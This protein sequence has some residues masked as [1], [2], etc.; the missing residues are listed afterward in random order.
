LA[1]FFAGFADASSGCG[2]GCGKLSD[3]AVL[4]TVGIPLGNGL[5]MGSCL[6]LWPLEN[7]GNGTNRRDGR[8]CI[9][10]REHR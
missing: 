9:A 10:V 2:A 6:T 7:R 3:R 5:D 1:L 8:R 4:M